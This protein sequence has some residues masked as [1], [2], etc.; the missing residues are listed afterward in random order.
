MSVTYDFWRVAL[1]GYCRTFLCSVTQ[2]AKGS[3]REAGE[4]TCR[5]LPCSVSGTAEDLE[6][7][8]RPCRHYC[9]HLQNQNDVW[10]S[11]MTGFPPVAESPT[12]EVPCQ[13]SHPPPPPPPPPCTNLNFHCV[14]PI[15]FSLQFPPIP[16]VLLLLL[17][18]PPPPPSRESMCLLCVLSWWS[19]VS[20]FYVVRWSSRTST[21]YLTDNSNS[22]LANSAGTLSLHWSIIMS[23]SLHNPLLSNP[24][25]QHASSKEQ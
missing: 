1:S 24:A 22:W 18:S 17:L 20:V 4:T 11:I 3:W 6:R 5:T 10:R 7:H 2:A 21:W 25:L 9:L 14:F 12:P 16:T 15:F 19:C 8:G 23:L 13:L